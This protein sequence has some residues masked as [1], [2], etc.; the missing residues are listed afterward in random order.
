MAAIQYVS[1]AFLTEIIAH[2]STA[3]A[4]VYMVLT[5]AVWT[6]LL[7]S[8]G[9]WETL[10][11]WLLSVPLCYPVL[12]YFWKTHYAVRAL[13]WVIPC[14]GGQSSGG[15][16]AGCVQLV[17][18]TGLCAAGLL[19]ALSRHPK[20]SGKDEAIRLCIGT[21]CTLGI[22][23]AVLLLERQFPSYQQ[24]LAWV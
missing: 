24:V 2:R 21:G 3:L 10:A 8:E 19:A 1:A 17:L 16:F 12:Q 14:Y 15:A 9:R 23:A 13:N 22:L 6:L 4:L 18:L 11:K 7:L 20:P 5:A